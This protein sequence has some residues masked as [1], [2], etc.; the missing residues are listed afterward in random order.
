[1]DRSRQPWAFSCDGLGLVGVPAWACTFSGTKALQP[2]RR[3]PTRDILRAEMLTSA[4]TA[5]SV[6]YVRALEGDRPASERL[7]DDPYAAIFHAAGG[8][9]AEGTRRFAELPMFVEG[10]RLRTRAID[11]FVREGVGAGLG[12]VVL[13]GAGFDARGLRLPEIAARG[14]MVYEV[15]FARQLEAKRGLLAG[16]GVSLPGWVKHVACDFSV[17]DFDVALSAHLAEQGFRAGQGALFVWE[18]VIAY[19]STDAVAR[20]LQ[21]MARAGGP[22]SR[23]V[24]DFAP[25]AFDPD[26]ALERTRRAGFTHFE[27]VGYDVLW[28]RFLPGEPPPSAFVMHMG[29]AFI[30]PR[31]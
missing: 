28:R 11:D 22:G 4:D 30:E 3:V 8:H 23:L 5:Y 7:F 13:L 25:I 1:M 12:Q 29:M 14:A 20:S 2:A 6:A 21:F 24:F 18:G 9:A 16:A 27:Q 15:D 10:V 31:P 19:I 26:P 17:A